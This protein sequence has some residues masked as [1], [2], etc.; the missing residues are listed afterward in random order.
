MPPNPA[1]EPCPHCGSNADVRPSAEVRFKCQMCGKARIPVDVRLGASSKK[2]TALLKA[3]QSSRFARIVWGLGSAALGFATFFGL[4]L[5]LGI[6]GFFDMG[7]LG[8][9]TALVFTLVPAL[10]AV[11]AFSFS[12][13]AKRSSQLKLDE[14]WQIAAARV[15]QRLGGRADASQLAQALSIDP[16]LATQLLAEAE[17]H[18]LLAADD[19]DEA[20]IRV[21]VAEDAEHEAAALEE[22][23][24]ALGNLPTQA[25]PARKD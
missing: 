1:I 9:S 10:A 20:P 25:L 17:V 2:A 16:E 11:L 6:V 5:Y 12:Q 24:R 18:Q 21:R 23:E 3:S 4:L 7:V 14:A 22:A 13:K 19:G 15:V 8:H